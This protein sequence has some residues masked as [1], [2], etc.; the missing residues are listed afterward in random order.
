MTMRKFLGE[1]IVFV[2]IDITMLLA[3]SCINSNIYERRF[4]CL[5]FNSV[6]S[7]ISL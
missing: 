2:T 6:L 3:I 1:H 5:R 7:F 4:L